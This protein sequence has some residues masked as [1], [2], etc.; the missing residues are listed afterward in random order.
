VDD[1]KFDKSSRVM[2]INMRYSPESQTVDAL[3]GD[4][5]ASRQFKKFIEDMGG[6]PIEGKKGKT[7]LG[8]GKPSVQLNIDGF[9]EEPINSAATD[10]MKGFIKKTV[11]ADIGEARKRMMSPP[12]NLGSKESDDALSALKRS[13]DKFTDEEWGK[14]ESLFADKKDEPAAV[15]QELAKW[16]LLQSEREYLEGKVARVTRRLAKFLIIQTRVKAAC[17]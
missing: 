1:V 4:G 2:N 10:A 9:D 14:M 3:F 16:P 15:A 6:E 13:R 11:R 17:M 7:M 8:K 12:A 5:A